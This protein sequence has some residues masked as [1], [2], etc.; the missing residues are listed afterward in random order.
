M[1][2]L[3]AGVCEDGAWMVADTAITGETMETRSREYKIKIEPIQDSALIGFANVP[4]VAVQTIRAA[5]SKAQGK[6]TV[7]FLLQ[8]HLNGQHADFMY[9]YIEDGVP[10]LYCIKDGAATN[11]AAAYIGSHD[12]F[13]AFQE[14]KHARALNPVPDAMEM[15]IGGVSGTPQLSADDKPQLYTN[16]TTAIHAMQKLFYKSSERGVGGTAIPYIV[17][18]AGAR[19]YNYG[20]SVTDPGINALKPGSLVMHGTPQLGGYGV[21]V[22]EL[23]ERDGIVIYW[24]QRPGGT[25]WV[26]S[27]DW[28]QPHHFSGSPSEFREAIKRTLG[29]EVDIWFGDQEQGTPESLRVL[30]DHAGRPRL[31]LAES[32]GSLSF[33][34]VQGSAD[35]FSISSSS[36]KIGDVT[37]LDENG[38]SDAKVA[39]TRSEDGLTA[40]LTMS[41]NM[42]NTDNVEL[43]AGDLDGLIRRLAR[44]RSEMS[45]EVAVEL[46]EGTMLDARI[47]P[48]WRTK[49]VLHPGIAGEL[50]ILR[51][52][53]LGWLAFLLPPHEAVALGNYLTKDSNNN[54]DV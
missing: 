22:T 17:T 36:I 20:Y 18:S 24:L 30:R 2:L 31:M 16:I 48:L 15:L 35:D 40:T 50:L 19:V 33:S 45:P 1:T 51:H 25:V 12:A 29:R 46:D 43:S 39:V 10:H 53:G 41:K 54:S 5:T 23:R 6:E 9:A 34:W 8:E 49:P 13:S 44:V 11:S 38:T 7:D 27:A 28:Y 4:S 14:I 3:V 47:D 42:E 52:A 21:S 37:M 26:K 32:R